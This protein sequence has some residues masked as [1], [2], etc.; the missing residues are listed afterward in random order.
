[1]IIEGQSI[2]YTNVVSKEYYIYYTYMKD[3][4]DDFMLEIE[5][6]NLTAKG[7][8]FYTLKN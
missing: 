8:L 2:A 4:I 1:M 5:K 6:A 7:P 3:S